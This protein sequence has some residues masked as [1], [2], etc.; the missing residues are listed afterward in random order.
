[1]VIQQLTTEDSS[2]HSV[3]TH[4]LPEWHPL[5]IDDNIATIIKF[6][7]LKKLNHNDK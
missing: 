7:Q 5:I 3:K 4:K 1:M 2:L 6:N